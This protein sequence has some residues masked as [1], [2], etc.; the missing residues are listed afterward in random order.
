MLA[1]GG[2]AWKGVLMLDEYGLIGELNE[3]GGPGRV[4]LSVTPSDLHLQDA[5]NSVALEVGRFLR[6]AP[7]VGDWAEKAAHA[8]SGW[9]VAS[10]SDGARLTCVFRGTDVQRGE[11]SWPDG[12][13]RDA[14]LKIPELLEHLTRA[15]RRLGDD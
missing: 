9:L 10:L 5:S 6:P 15:F 13:R 12:L 2:S 4:V 1:F 3:Q 7:L 11:L 14:V 8:V